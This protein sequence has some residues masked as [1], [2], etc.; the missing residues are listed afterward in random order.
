MGKGMGGG[1]AGESYK[2]NDEVENAEFVSITDVVEVERDV[3]INTF[4]TNLT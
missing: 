4:S 3:N 1:D 2:V